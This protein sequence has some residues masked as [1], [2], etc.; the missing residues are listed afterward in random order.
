MWENIRPHKAIGPGEH[1]REEI[2]SRGWSEDE[3]ADILGIS[4][5]HLS[6]LLND[7]THMTIPL[8]RLVGKAFGTTPQFWMNLYINYVDNGSIG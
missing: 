4:E 6:E 7:K 5:K 8:A 2:E 3:F 1:I